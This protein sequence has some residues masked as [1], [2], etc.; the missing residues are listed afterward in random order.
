MR[1][2]QGP[3][4]GELVEFIP[5]A[6]GN[7]GDPDPVRVWLRR[8]TRAEKRDH[9][10]MLSGHLVM[11]IGADGGMRVDKKRAE[12]ELPLAEIVSRVRA[13]LVAHV[14]KI[15]GYVDKLGAAIV[16]GA[17][18]FERGEDEFRDEVYAEIG[19]MLAYASAAETCSPLTRLHL[20]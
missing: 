8:P 7:R 14:S 16:D 3:K 11:R 15:E 1:K 2:I 9:V 12:L 19:K 20:H 13:T 17:D 18:L 10:L 5:S 4:P 6:F